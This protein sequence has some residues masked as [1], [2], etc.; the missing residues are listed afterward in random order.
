MASQGPRDGSAAGGT[1]WTSPAN[2]KVMDSVVATNAGPNN[3]WLVITNFGFSIPAG[4]TITGVQIGSIRAA[5][6]SLVDTNK[7]PS[8]RQAQLTEI[9]L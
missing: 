2:A 6:P 4:A 9:A 5:F 1:N 7:F 3:D 8:V